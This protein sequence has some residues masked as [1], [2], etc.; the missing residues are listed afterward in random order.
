MR[1]G[2]GK[3]TIQ[4]VGTLGGQVGIGIQRCVLISRMS[5]RRAGD[6]S[7][8]CP[9]RAGACHRSPMGADIYL[10]GSE[11]LPLGVCPHVPGVL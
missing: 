5:C 6:F 10:E 2:G 7:R 9:F 1:L 8:G 11:A 3:K 4:I